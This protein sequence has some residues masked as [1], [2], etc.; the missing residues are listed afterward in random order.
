M[1]N[2]GLL[3]VTRG[4]LAI[5][6]EVGRS[7]DVGRSDNSLAPPRSFI[8]EVVESPGLICSPSPPLLVTEYSYI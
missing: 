6:T 1:L 4:G 3:L 8:T 2:A 5:G 7:D